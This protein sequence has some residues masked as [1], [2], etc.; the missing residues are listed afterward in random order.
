MR[1]CRYPRLTAG[2]CRLY[3]LAI[4]MYPPSLRREFH[5]ELAIT[6]RNRA[7]DVLNSGSLAVALAFALHLVGDWLRTF[8][9][10]TDDPPVL[11]LLGLGGGDA[12]ACGCIDRTTLS[13]S[14]MLATLGVLLLIGGWYGWL[15][16]NAEI[17][18][19]HRAL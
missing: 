12:P 1:R 4:W 15:S 6:F 10:K 13:V 18:Q 7:E 5:R 2:V 14:L 16:L 8:T 3:G 9:L 17:L 19:H 11:S